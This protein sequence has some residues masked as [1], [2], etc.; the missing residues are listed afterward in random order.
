[1]S[2]AGDSPA[3]AA[4]KAGNEAFA[5]KEYEAAIKHYDKAISLDGNNATYYSNRSAC[6]AALKKWTE[7]YQD[8]LKCVEKDPKF[9]KGFLRLATAQIELDQLD[10]AETTLR[11][12]L[13]LDNQ[14][15][16]VG[17]LLRKLRE[18]KNAG[19][20]EKKQGRHLDEQQRK[21]LAELQEQTGAYSRDLSGVI[22][23]MNAIQREAQGTHNSS[24][25]L[26]GFDE[27][28]PMYLAVGKTYIRHPRDKV[29]GQLESE[30]DILDKNFKDLKDRREYLERRI[31]S[32]KS[33]IKDLTE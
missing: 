30:L 26:E 4:K 27:N 10:D 6:Y 2:E 3:D 32:N 18:K 16:M 11:A 21:E 15:A 13:T 23:R 20:M 9:Q 29:K 5:K 24:V 33:G 28:T 22:A 12:A 25:Q 8:A 31:T 19:S 1:M 17:T 7:A 14:N